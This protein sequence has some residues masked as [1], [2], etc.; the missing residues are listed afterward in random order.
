[1]YFFVFTSKK[2]ALHSKNQ[3]N[4]V[5]LHRRYEIATQFTSPR[6]GGIVINLEK[7]ER[8]VFKASRSLSP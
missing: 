3:K 1:M 5:P 7:G 2:D 4:V 6:D 8:G